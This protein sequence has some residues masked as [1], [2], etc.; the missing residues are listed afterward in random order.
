MNRV[1]I[2]SC[3]WLPDRLRERTGFRCL[4]IRTG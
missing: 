1:P 3:A 4:D 2:I